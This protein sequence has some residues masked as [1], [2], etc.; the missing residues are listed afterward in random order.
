MRYAPKRVDRPALTYRLT[1]AA[2]EDLVHIYIE[3]VVQFGNR[4]AD[5]YHD[6]LEQTFQLIAENPGIARER[7]EIAP[8][9]RVHPCGSHMII[10]EIEELDVLILRVRHHREDWANDP[11]HDD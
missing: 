4:Q 11:V 7:S 2:A 1:E 9:V 3:G 5:A 8:P 10:Y 6:R